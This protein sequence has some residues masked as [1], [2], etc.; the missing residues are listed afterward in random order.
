MVAVADTHVCCQQTIKCLPALP[1]LR[2]NLYLIYIPLDYVTVW[3]IL[4]WKQYY[5]RQY[6][7]S[8]LPIT[9]YFAIVL[10]MSL[11]Q[12]KFDEVRASRC[13]DL[14][15]CIEYLEAVNFSYITSVSCANEAASLFVINFQLR[16]IWTLTL[17]ISRI[18]N[19]CLS[20][21]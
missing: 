18:K 15:G 17:A 14:Q 6:F 5:P 3:I 21:G 16:F 13:I 12:C 4:I 1:T 19:E 9:D 8:I 20:L 10:N 11:T 7:L 2:F